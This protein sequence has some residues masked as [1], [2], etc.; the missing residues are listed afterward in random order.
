VIG[1]DIDMNAIELSDD[2]SPAEGN[3]AK[4]VILSQAS[5]TWLLRG[6]AFR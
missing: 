4:G 3:H 5:A 2:V 1:T 6:H